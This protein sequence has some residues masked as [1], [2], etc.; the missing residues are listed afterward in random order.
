MCFSSLSSKIEAQTMTL[1]FNGPHCVTRTRRVPQLLHNESFSPLCKFTQIRLPGLYSNT[2][3]L[4]IYPFVLSSQI[5]QRK[6]MIFFG[7][8]SSYPL[9][10]QKF[11]TCLILSSC[12]C[13]A[14]HG[15]HLLHVFIWL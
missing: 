4:E 7:L 5:M 9:P 15:P 8:C 3:A 13:P 6:T 14:H 11:S 10:T 12:G 2:E 1:P